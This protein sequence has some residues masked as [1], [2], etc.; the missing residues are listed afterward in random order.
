METVTLTTYP[1]HDSIK[2]DR[3]EYAYYCREFTI[4]KEYALKLRSRA[5]CDQTWEEF[6][7]TYTWDDTDGWIEEAQRAGMLVKVIEIPDN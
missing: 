7:D 5:D 6:I 2:D 4:S 1:V 3:E